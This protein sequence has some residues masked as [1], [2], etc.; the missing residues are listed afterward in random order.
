MKREHILQNE[1]CWILLIP[2]DVPFNIKADD[3]VPLCEQPFGPAAK[4]TK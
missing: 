4:S 3:I 2:I 1:L